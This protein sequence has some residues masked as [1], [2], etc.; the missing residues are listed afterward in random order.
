ML[1]ID[2]IASRLPVTQSESG[3]QPSALSARPM[4][5]NLPEGIQRSNIALPYKVLH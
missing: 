2:S 5:F 3:S 1:K 4:S